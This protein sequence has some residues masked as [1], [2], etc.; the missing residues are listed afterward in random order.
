MITLKNIFSFILLVT[1]ILLPSCKVVMPLPEDLSSK[2]LNLDIFCEDL[3]ITDDR[4]VKDTID[5]ITPIVSLRKKEI[6]RNPPFTKN[7]RDTISTLINSQ[8]KNG[9]VG[10]KI[11][12]HIL[13]AYKEFSVLP[14]EDKEMAKCLVR[15]RVEII[16]PQR[17]YTCSGHGEY[18]VKLVDVNDKGFEQLYCRTLKNSIYQALAELQSIN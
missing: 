10:S 1:V 6:K 11:S 3:I 16:E 15:V 9:K 5:L 13:E 4:L 17:K 2:K 7:H 12:V 18:F 8:L 14:F